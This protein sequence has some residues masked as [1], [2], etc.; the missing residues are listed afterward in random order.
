[1]ADNRLGSN[2]RASLRDFVGG[3][4]VEDLNVG[5]WYSSKVPPSAGYPRHN[6]PG[7]P[8]GLAYRG[9]ALTDTH[10]VCVGGGQSGA[11]NTVDIVSL[12][13][14]E[15]NSLFFELPTA[16]KESVA[17]AH[18]GK[19]Y[20]GGGGDTN[21][22]DYLDVLE[23]ELDGGDLE[24][25][26]T[27]GSFSSTDHPTFWPGF[28]ID[29]DGIAYLYGGYSSTFKAMDLSDGS[30]VAVSNA[31]VNIGGARGTIIN[32]SLYTST[33]DSA[34][35]QMIRYDIEEDSWSQVGFLGGWV[36]GETEAA[37]DGDDTIYCHDGY[38]N[39][40]IYEYS[41]SGQSWSEFEHEFAGTWGG[42]GACAAE[43][44][45]GVLYFYGGQSESMGV[46]DVAAVKVR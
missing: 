41:I 31:P 30:S 10:M 20:V 11:V 38:Y 13:T 23:L 25:V 12:E 26:S 32:G 39:N 14:G 9:V 21:F 29:S 1:M 45:D 4:P 35:T 2:F 15:R 6:T 19:V 16:I 44:E 18:D 40:N 3:D 7:M 5:E 33:G 27:V 42:I 24:S 28:N 22:D 37:Y 17:Q 36:I 43:Y 8:G 46:S 34:E